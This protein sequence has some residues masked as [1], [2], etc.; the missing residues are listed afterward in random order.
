MANTSKKFAEW[1][2]ITE[3]HAG[4]GYWRLDTASGDIS[5]SPNMF[6]LFGFPIGEEPPVEEAMNRVHPHDRSDAYADLSRDL[7]GHTRTSVTRIL[8][9]CGS[10][11]LI[12]GRTSLERSATGDI[13]AVCGVV[14]DVTDR[15]AADNR[16]ADGAA[17]MPDLSADLG[18]EL[19]TPLTT[20]VGYAHLL[21]TSDAVP[22]SL[23]REAQLIESASRALL[24]IANNTLGQARGEAV[25]RKDALL[26]TPIAE[27]V[28]ECLD[29]FR[30]Q[31]EQKGLRFHY[32]AAPDMP[33][34]VSV[35][36]SSLKQILINLVGNAVKFTT[37]GWVS[38]NVAFNPERQTLTVEVEDTGQGLE[39]ETRDSLFQRFARGNSPEGLAAPGAGLG[40]SIVKG[41]VNAL[42]G[43]I[44][45]R[46][47]VGKGTLFSVSLPAHVSLD[48]RAVA[49][50]SIPEGTRV[51]V[52]DDNASIREIARRIL[53]AAGAVVALADSGVAALEIC[54]SHPFDVVL[55]DINMPDLRGE[56]V[57][58]EMR[59]CW[60][61]NVPA[62]LVAFSAAE[63][64]PAVLELFDDWI[65]K[66]VDPREL[67]QLVWGSRISRAA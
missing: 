64:T 59:R 8:L 23:R 52:V 2:A 44:T 53:E 7:Q 15:M 31:A 43:A 35:A 13:V 41:L 25:A 50:A 28:R 62:R 26:D 10:I 6:R 29:L 66:P 55:L 9:P 60:T 32:R 17:A 21:A 16:P 63:P 58:V 40:L 24:S 45:V 11:R 61:S 54:S 5:W 34:Q 49:P 22:P 14:I 65:R 48:L 56:A 33:A 51:L 39:E 47:T 3:E 30:D 46:S 57:A 18:H 20:I 67:V 38:V 4:L 1:N 12:E 42:D 27:L 36:A 37:A 19:R